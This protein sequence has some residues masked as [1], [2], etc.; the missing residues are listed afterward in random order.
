MATNKGVNPVLNE[1]FMM[2][3]VIMIIFVTLFNISNIVSISL[4]NNQLNGNIPNN[5]SVCYNF[6]NYNIILPNKTCYSYMYLN[7]ANNKFINEQT[8]LCC[9][10]ATK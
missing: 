8:N 2:H 3:Q 7:L 1:L 6:Y 4:N 10:R 9:G 5:I